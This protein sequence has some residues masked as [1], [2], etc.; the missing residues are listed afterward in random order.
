[1]LFLYYYIIFLHANKMQWLDFVL[2]QSAEELP[3]IFSTSY[4]DDE[5]T[6]S[7]FYCVVF[8]K[9]YPLQVP[10]SYARRVCNSMA[11]LGARGV[12]LFFSSG[13]YGVGDGSTNPNSHKCYTNDDKA[14]VKFIPVFPATVSF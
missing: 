6:V 3:Q 2:S 13:D 7:L 9:S 12:T 1:M 5:Q 4:G 11:Q 8:T 14:D 10:E